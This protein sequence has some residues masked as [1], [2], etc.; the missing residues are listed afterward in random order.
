MQDTRGKV[1]QERRDSDFPE[2]KFQFGR[3]HFMAATVPQFQ[4]A[5]Y[6]PVC[7]FYLFYIYQS[8]HYYAFWCIYLA[9]EH[10]FYC[11]CY[12][13]WCYAKSPLVARRQIYTQI[14]REDRRVRNGKSLSWIL[15]LCAVVV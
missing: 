6:F 8:M 5:I 7:I 11:Y 2:K 10:C 13:Y 9:I 4:R 1:D 15:R 14:Y 3:A 12:Y